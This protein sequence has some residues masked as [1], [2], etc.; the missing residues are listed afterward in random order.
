[1]SKATDENEIHIIFEL[2]IET[3]F[4]AALALPFKYFF[5]FYNYYL[6]QLETDNLNLL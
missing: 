2:R 4:L 6:F 5:F 1:M 3:A